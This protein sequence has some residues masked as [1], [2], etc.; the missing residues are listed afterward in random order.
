M[1]AT[2]AFEFQR[3]PS[4]KNKIRVVNIITGLDTGGAEHALELVVSLLDKAIFDVSVISLRDLGL[5]GSRLRQQ[6]VPVYA[7]GLRHAVTLPFHLLRLTLLLCRLRPQ[8]VQTW[9]YHAD[10]IGLLAAKLAGAPYVLWNLRGSNLALGGNGVP[11]HGQYRFLLRC[12]AWLSAAPDVVISNSQAGIDF[13]ISAGYRPRRV[14]KITNGVDFMR[15]PA[16]DADRQ[17]LRDACDFHSDAVVVG[18]IAR[19]DPMKNHLAFLQMAILLL[20]RG[21]DV[22]FVM[23]GREVAA[24]AIITGF[25]IRNP[26]LAARVKLL[27]ERRDVPELMVGLDLLCSTSIW[28]EGTPNVIA[29]AMLSSVAVVATDVGDTS[30]LLS[31]TGRI[32]PV[33]DVPALALACEEL[34]RC[35]STRLELVKAARRRAI[36]LFRPETMTAAYERTYLD[37]VDADYRHEAFAASAVATAAS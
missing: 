26:R 8:I 1:D 32:V 20:D 13:H 6:G 24:D 22:R 30:H 19:I 12:L 9:L 36:E 33:N 3:T 16:V 31:D 23:I 4:R 35:P 34:L 18:H 37:V 11:G 21:L 2:T 15:F 27:G 5:V 7:I 25:L 17:Y 10:L 29:E 14:V 28:G